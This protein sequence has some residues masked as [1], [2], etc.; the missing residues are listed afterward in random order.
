M[1]KI[2]GQVRIC[3]QHSKQST[4]HAQTTPGALGSETHN[5]EM[6]DILKV[7]PDSPAEPG[8]HAWAGRRPRGE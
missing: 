3:F 7:S 1:V 6:F 8:V 5:L 4:K 2:V